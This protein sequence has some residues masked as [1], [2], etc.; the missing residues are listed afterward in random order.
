MSTPRLAFLTM[1][2]MFSGFLLNAKDI[3]AYFRWWEAFSFFKYAVRAHNNGGFG[4]DAPSPPHPP[5]H[6]LLR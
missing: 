6:P 4:G 3:P 5:P 2:V 1:Q